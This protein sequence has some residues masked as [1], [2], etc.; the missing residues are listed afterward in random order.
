MTDTP[1]PAAATESPPRILRGRMAYTLGPLLCQGDL[2]TLYR[3]T[4]DDEGALNRVVIKITRD[5]A[6]NDLALNEASIVRTL[7]RKSF[8]EGDLG[9]YFPV[10]V[11][12]FVSADAASGRHQTNVIDW[13][14]G[15]YSFA[16]IRAAYSQG[17]DIR[18][19]V[20]M[21][22]RL[23]KALSF[24]HRHGIIHGSVIPPHVLPHPPS[25]GLTLI[26]WSYAVVEPQRTGQRVQAISP[27]W[28]AF[29]PPEILEK[30]LPTPATDI[31][32]WAK[33]AIYLLG[34]DPATN[35]LPREIPRTIKIFLDRCLLERMSQRQND[36]ER[37]R[38]QLHDIVTDIW[39]PA[40]RD[41][42]MPESVSEPDDEQA[43]PSTET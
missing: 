16:E 18:D 43:E 25:H 26:D 24:A 27:E 12:S 14:D 17:I 15:R 2:A 30:R 28:E 9:F 7:N 6:D 4:Y 13:L 29:Y 34:G 31:Y 8:G 38:R 22:K 21:W 35:S 41:F 10:F 42:T 40:F 3:A 33:C 23:L 39:E 1:V 20:W 37:L 32:M 5:P 19:A 11:E 36:A